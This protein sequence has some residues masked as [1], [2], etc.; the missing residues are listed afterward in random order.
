[1][2]IHLIELDRPL[3]K[4]YIGTL[5]AQLKNF[6]YENKNISKFKND[7]TSE[8]YGSLGYLAS[9]DL[10]KLKGDVEQF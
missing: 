5:L 6:N 1:M 10:F 3:R 4:K 8:F 9:M 2:L 7:A